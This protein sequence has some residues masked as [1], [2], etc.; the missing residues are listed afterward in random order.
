MREIREREREKPV[1]MAVTTESSPFTASSSAWDPGGAAKRLKFVGILPKGVFR[2]VLG[3][4]L[5][6]VPLV[7]PSPGVG[8]SSFKIAHLGWL[9]LDT[10][11]G[12]LFLSCSSRVM[13]FVDIRVASHS[14]SASQID[15]RELRS[16]GCRQNKLETSAVRFG[17]LRRSARRVATWKCPRGNP[18]CVSLSR[19]TLSF[20]RM[21]FLAS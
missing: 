4:V 18:I 6:W 3:A 17:R 13:A 7:D 2:Q 5:P 21:C 20:E 19:P 12:D 1:K 8:K 10:P 16:N 14:C 11:T 15:N 9:Q